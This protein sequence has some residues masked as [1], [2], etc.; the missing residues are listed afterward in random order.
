LDS[1]EAVK[2]LGMGA[3]A[4]AYG[5]DRSVPEPMRVAVFGVA[6]LWSLAAALHSAE[7]RAETSILALH[8]LQSALVSTPCYFRQQA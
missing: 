2:G 3:M 4:L 1:S 8:P 7:H 6:T 5:A